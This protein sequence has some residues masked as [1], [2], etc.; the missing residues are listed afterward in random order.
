MT[1]ISDKEFAYI[2]KW[3]YDRSGIRLKPIKKQLVTGRLDKRL[4]VLGLNSYGQYIRFLER[5]ETECEY[6]IN[7]LT[8]NETYFFREQQH[9]DYLIQE[10]LPNLKSC[11]TTR[12]WSAA[13][14]TGAESYT[15]AFC[16]AHYLGVTG[17]W[18]IIGTDINTEVLSVA[19]RGIYPMQAAEKIPQKYLKAY[20]LKGKGKDKGFFKIH[21]D[22]MARV[23]FQSVNLFEPIPIRERFDVVFLRNV[24]IYF[25]PEEKARILNH[26]VECIRPGGWLIVGHSES[27]YGFNNNLEQLGPGCYRRH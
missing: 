3:L 12:F 24:L 10:I 25:E 6:V 23:H 16:L 13:A 15:L 1:A 5:S 4:R 2:S 7:Q 22:L 27:I 17:G 11:G 19:D 21:P 9:F 14:S 26:V 18:Q 20:C 8:T